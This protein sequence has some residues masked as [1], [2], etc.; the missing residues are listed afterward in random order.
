MSLPPLT[1]SVS[2]DKSPCLSLSFFNWEMGTGIILTYCGGCRISQCLQPPKNSMWRRAGARS[3]FSTSALL[4]L[5]V[6]VFVVRAV[7]C[8]AGCLYPPSVWVPVAPP[9]VTIRN[10]SRSCQVSTGEGHHN[11]SPGGEPLG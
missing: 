6:R 10:V 9:A 11:I 1:S 4:T 8:I 7:L 2:L 3:R 5:G